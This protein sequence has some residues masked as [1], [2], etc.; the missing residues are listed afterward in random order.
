MV[1]KPV[2]EDPFMKN[3]ALASGW[4][5]FF[6]TIGIITLPILLLGVPVIFIALKTHVA[7]DDEKREYWWLGNRSIPFK[8]KTVARAPTSGVLG[9]MMSPLRITRDD[10]KSYSFP[11]GTFHRKAELIATITARTGCSLYS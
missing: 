11:M 1:G 7:I 2:I 4:R 5:A 3:Y 8:G 10:S 6:G 9:A